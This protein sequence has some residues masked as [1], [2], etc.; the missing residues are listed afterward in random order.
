MIL[1][2]LEK[3][4]NVDLTKEKSITAALGEG[5]INAVLEYDIDTCNFLLNCKPDI[6][7]YQRENSR[8]AL[9]EAVAGP[10]HLTDLI[11]FLVQKGAD[12]NIRDKEGETAANSK[13]IPTFT[14]LLKAGA[15]V[16]AEIHGETIL[17]VILGCEI[18]SLIKHTILVR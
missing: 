17:S 16:N 4:H 15:D 11:P 14:A 10:D 7:N 13:V 1:E 8:T 12:V 3:C 2:I 18:F 5:F 6:I 9:Q